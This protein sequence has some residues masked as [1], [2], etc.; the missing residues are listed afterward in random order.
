M[1]PFSLSSARLTLKFHPNAATFEAGSVRRCG[2]FQLTYERRPAGS[3]SL[4]GSSPSAASIGFH[5]EPQ[6]RN[7][8]LA[9]EAVGAILTAA[10]NLGLTHISAQCR[11]DNGPSRRVLEKNGFSLG[12]AEPFAPHQK[13]SP[14]QYMVYHRL[15]AFPE[16]HRS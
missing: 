12:S 2:A 15:L 3:V 13:V 6:F 10:A 7:L 11:S 14:I 16:S 9:S 5:I 8:G 1:T 4:V